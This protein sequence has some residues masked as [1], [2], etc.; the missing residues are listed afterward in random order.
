MSRVGWEQRIARAADLEV[1]YPDAAPILRF[2]RQV[3]Q[4]QHQLYREFESGQRDAIEEK[5]RAFLDCVAATGPG[6][7]AEEAAALRNRGPA[8][9]EALLEAAREGLHPARGFSAA[10]FLARAFLQPWAEASYPLPRAEEC[11]LTSACPCCGREPQAAVLQEEQYGARRSLVCSFCQWE[12][13]FGRRLCPA[14]SEDRSDYLPMFRAEDFPALFVEVCDS[15]R[16]YLLAVNI[17][18]DAAAVAT[19]DDLAAESLH[20]WAG[21]HGYQLLAP[22]WPAL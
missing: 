8:E 2:Y 16:T 17:T 4:A 19:V 9:L 5:L 6:A 11:D 20:A 10:D 22:H 7:A 3:A 14:C 13:E 1:R 18:L 15:C 21:E 12:W